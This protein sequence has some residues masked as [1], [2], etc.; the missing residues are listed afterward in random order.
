MPKG[1]YARK[2][3]EKDTPQKR[4]AKTKNRRMLL[5]HVDGFLSGYLLATFDAGHGI[6]RNVKQIARIA[7][8]GFKA[9]L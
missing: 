1:I 6:K 9:G 4:G 8:D 5:T 3:A 7:T 2:K